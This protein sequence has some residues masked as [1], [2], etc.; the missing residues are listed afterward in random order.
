MTTVGECARWFDTDYQDRT[1]LYFNY[2]RDKER[3]PAGTIWEYDSAGSQVLSNL[4]AKRSGMST[5][6]DLNEKIF[7]HLGT[8]KTATMLKTRN[9]DSW[10]DSALICT[11]RDMMSFARF[12]M[13]YGTWNGV[14]LMNEEYLRDA[15]AKH[16]ATH[17]F[18]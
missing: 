4:V 13:N 11:S 5:F 6:E 12:V 17:E 9:G 16:A 14:R 3:R 18:D 2:N 7:R 15:T 1:E 8:F 10:G